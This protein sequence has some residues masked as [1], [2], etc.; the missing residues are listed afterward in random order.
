MNEKHT[1]AAEAQVALLVQRGM[2]K[3]AAARAIGISR[4]TLY[5]WRQKYPEFDAKLEEAEA[6]YMQGL[7]DRA[8]AIANDADDRMSANMVQFLLER[9]WPDWWGRRRETEPASDGANAA[10]NLDAESDGSETEGGV[11]TIAGLLHRSGVGAAPE[12][13]E[14]KAHEVHPA[15]ANGHTNGIP[16]RSEP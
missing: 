9:R 4:V 6:T 7:I 11:L 1:E 8:L 15:Q 3:A 14:A 2:P 13:T 12:G 5:Q 10:S 16:A